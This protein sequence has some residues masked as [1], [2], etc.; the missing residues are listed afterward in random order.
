[1]N[2]DINYYKDC[3]CITHPG[4]CPVHKKNETSPVKEVL[5]M[6]WMCP[7][8]GRGNSPTA[9]TCLC[10]PFETKVTC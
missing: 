2:G 4:W 10:V 3:T 1:M 8:C 7:R 9:Q 6:G 5:S